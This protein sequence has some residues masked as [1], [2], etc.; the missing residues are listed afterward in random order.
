MTKF[1]ARD[2]VLRKEND[3]FGI[4]MT[5]EVRDAGLSLKNERECGIRTPLPD[6]VSR[7]W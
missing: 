7:V 6:L 3:L 5:P 2:A 4:E 1:S